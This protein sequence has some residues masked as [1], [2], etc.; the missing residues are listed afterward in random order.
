MLNEAHA[1][2]INPNRFAL[3][4]QVELLCDETPWVC[5]RTVMPGATL[6]GPLRKLAHLKSQSLGAILFASPS[7]QR[8]EV[9]ISNISSADKTHRLLEQ[10]GANL[11]A[12]LWG[13]RSVFRVYGK[14]LL[15]C[16][17]FLPAM[18]KLHF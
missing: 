9:E 14:P 16:E 13:R 7:M 6:S 2:G 12:S 11:P 1:L 5:A 17:F 10:G 4:R 15:V 18:E 8:G 3:I